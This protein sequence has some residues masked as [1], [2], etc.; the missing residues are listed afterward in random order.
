LQSFPLINY[1]QAAI[2]TFE[3]IVRKPVVIQ[4]DMIAIRSM[5]NLCLSLDHRILDGVICG[6]FMQRVKQYLERY[7]QDTVIY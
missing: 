5:A 6:H 1:P 4:R 7:D 2:I 3:T